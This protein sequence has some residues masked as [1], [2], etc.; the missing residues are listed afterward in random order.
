M[1]IVLTSLTSFNDISIVDSATY[2]CSQVDQ[3][4]SENMRIS[5][6]VFSNDLHYNFL[7]KVPSS[8]SKMRFNLEFSSHKTTKL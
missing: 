3:L 7:G 5:P 8:L 2:S 6:E 4:Q 1:E